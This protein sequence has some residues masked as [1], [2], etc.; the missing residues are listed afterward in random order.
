VDNTRSCS[1]S[2]MRLMMGET[3]PETCRYD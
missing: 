1:Y 3:S 2:D